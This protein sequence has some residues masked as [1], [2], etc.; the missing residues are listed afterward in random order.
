MS[1]KIPYSKELSDFLYSFKIPE[2]EL[3]AEFSG[4][5]NT[6]PEKS[7]DDFV[8][9]YFKEKAISFTKSANSESEL[10]AN[11]RTIYLHMACYKT[12]VNDNLK[13][14]IEFLKGHYKYDL[15]QN[16]ASSLK[17]KVSVIGDKDCLKCANSKLQRTLEYEV[18]NQR[19]PFADCPLSKDGHSL[20]KAPYGYSVKRDEN[21]LPVNTIKKIPERNYN[22]NTKY[23]RRKLREHARQE[24]AGLSSK[25]K[26]ER[27]VIAFIIMA[28]ICLIVW[29]LLGTE[30]FLKWSQH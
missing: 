17:M 22:P 16:Q 2:E 9:N 14:G 26:L 23:G 25:E 19:L 18:N 20:Y 7:F 3:S 12:Y 6:N 13:E 8:W 24:Y 10:Y 1:A 29:F 27:N 28:I 11:M 21:G 15:L 4:W 5:A 30:G